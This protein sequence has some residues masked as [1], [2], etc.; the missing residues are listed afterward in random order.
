MPE[1]NKRLRPPAG[2]KFATVLLLLILLPLIVIQALQRQTLR[3]NAAGGTQDRP[4]VIII[5]TDDQ[6]DNTMEFL[7]KTMNKLGNNGVYFNRAYVTT[8]WCCPSRSSILTGEYA[9]NH[10]VLTNNAPLGGVERFHDQQT[11]PVWLHNAGYKTA[12]IG[13]YLNHYDEIAPYKP[14]GW[15]KWFAF[16]NDNGRYTDYDITTN[17]QTAKH[18]GNTRDD[19][20]TDVFAREAVDFIRQT[21]QPFFLYFAPHAPHGHPEPAPRDVNNCPNA[22]LRRTANF[23]EAN[24]SDKPRWVRNN[25]RLR[26]RDIQELRDNY[27]DS[28]CTLPAVDDAVADIVNALGNKRDNTVIIFL[29]DNGFLFG[30]HRLANL[31]DSS[32]GGKDCFYEECIAVDMLISYPPLTR[33]KKTTDQFALNIDLAPTILELT[34]V[35]P[36]ADFRIDGK[37]LVPLLH[38]PELSLPIHDRF[39]IES[40]NKDYNGEDY[41]IRVDRYKYQLLSSGEKELYDLYA[42]PHEI[43]NL[44]GKSEYASIQQVLADSLAALENNEDPPSLPAALRPV[45]PNDYRNDETYINRPDVT[46]QYIEGIDPAEEKCT[47]DGKE[48]TKTEVGCIPRE[49]VEF[50]GVFYRIGLGIIGGL[51]LL[52][53][54]MGGYLILTSEGKPDRLNNGKKFILYAIIGLLL[55]IFGY[56]FLEVIA[57]DIL[58]LPGFY[59]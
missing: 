18:Y 52:F 49:P 59:H 8:G 29:S 56:I 20:S 57:V 34:R 50:A 10:G 55:G 6:P 38:N 27:K 45:Y 43:N 1:L 14:P 9:H 16:N 17:N 21:N 13:K 2:W 46:G 25:N 23:N 51:A 40:Y 33:G 32:G 39:A 11:L 53:V 26:Q 44:A 54:I 12:L 30:E 3:Q 15:D 58:H 22:P 24:V 5:L 7:P 28:M 35:T 42:D 31:K 36:P 19:Y 41:G 48:G 47:V 4:N 37:S